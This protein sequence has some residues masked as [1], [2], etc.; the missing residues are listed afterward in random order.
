MQAGE[1]DMEGGRWDGKEKKGRLTTGGVIRL[2]YD[3]G[4]RSASM[5]RET[6]LREESEVLLLI[7]S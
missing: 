1:T 2:P 7:R 3:H 4:V 6:D 5:V